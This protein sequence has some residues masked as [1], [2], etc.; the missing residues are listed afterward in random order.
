MNEK[1]LTAR[2]ADYAAAIKGGV[3]KFGSWRATITPKGSRVVTP[4]HKT[5]P[6]GVNGVNGINGKLW[7]PESSPRFESGIE[8]WEVLEKHSCSL[9]DLV[10]ALEAV[11]AKRG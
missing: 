6:L 5:D 8:G 2:Y 1:P 11:F 4:V 10:K 9:D 7:T 3:D